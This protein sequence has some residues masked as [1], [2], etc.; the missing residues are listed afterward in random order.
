M[1]GIE[2]EGRD[3][4]VRKSE[5]P[6]GVFVLLRMPMIERRVSNE[7]M[8]NKA[9]NYRRVIVLLWSCQNEQKRDF[10]C[11][12]FGVSCTRQLAFVI[13]TAMRIMHTKE[14]LR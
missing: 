11:R 10:H 5:R 3:S 13:F 14:R 4:Q 1:T 12:I 8:T 6:R 7:Q 2:S 9:W